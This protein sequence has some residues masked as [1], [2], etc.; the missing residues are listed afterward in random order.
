MYLKDCFSTIINIWYVKQKI[1]D[2]VIDTGTSN[3]HSD[4]KFR[5]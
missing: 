4:T 5:C 3:T 1:N 2:Y